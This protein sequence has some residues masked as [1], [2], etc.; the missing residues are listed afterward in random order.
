MP[1]GTLAT[2]PHPRGARLGADASAHHDRLQRIAARADHRRA[3]RAPTRACEELDRDPP[4]RLPRADRRRDAVGARACRAGC[5]PTTTIPIGP[6]RHAPTSAAP[7]ASTAWAWRTATAGACRRSR[8]STT[9]GRCRAC[10]ERASYFALIR[11]FR[12][13]SWLLLYLFGAS[14]AV[15]SSFV[16]GR[17]ARAA[18]RS[19]ADTLYMPH[20]HVAAHG[21]PRLP[22]RRAGA[23]WR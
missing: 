13:H 15:C 18:A 20:A 14:P 11:N 21:A 23:R 7:R 10:I 2:T 1:D 5:R 22:E 4:V 12:R 3:R 9:T 16:A 19:R 17:D 6:L 8:A